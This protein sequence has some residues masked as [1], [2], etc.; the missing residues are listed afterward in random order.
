MAFSLQEFDDE[1]LGEIA[2]SITIPKPMILW[3]EREG[4]Y[5]VYLE[6]DFLHIQD[7]KINVYSGELYKFSH[8]ADEYE[9]DHDIYYFFNERTGKLLYSEHG[10][11]LTVC[12]T[13]YLHEIGKQVDSVADLLC[14]YLLDNG[15]FLRKKVLPRKKL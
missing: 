8:D 12:I 7:L 9:L 3:K 10:S 1:G 11:S 5:R 4:D 2:A 14:T 13:N 6:Q 15:N